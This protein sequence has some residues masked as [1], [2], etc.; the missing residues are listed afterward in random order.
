ML[1]KLYKYTSTLINK[2]YPKF[3]EIKVARL[4]EELTKAN[5][6]LRVLNTS[7]GLTI[8]MTSRKQTLSNL[9]YKF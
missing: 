4:L 5:K 2:L 8:K 7:I 1:S 6:Y 9:G 3:K